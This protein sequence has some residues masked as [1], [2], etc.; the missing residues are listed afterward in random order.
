MRKVSIATY[1]VYRLLLFNMVSESSSKYNDTTVVLIV[2]NP[3]N[4][5]SLPIS[6]LTGSAAKK[7]GDFTETIL[8]SLQFHVAAKPAVLYSDPWKV[9][10][11]TMVLGAAPTGN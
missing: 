4:L 7:N 9:R 11:T 1:S 10:F 3:N 6:A 8:V 5:P 2:G